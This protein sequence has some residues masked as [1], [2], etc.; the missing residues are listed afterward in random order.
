MPD[1]EITGVDEAQ[2]A[3]EQEEQPQVE[4]TDTEPTTVPVAALED[5][6]RKRQQAEQ[7]AYQYQQALIQQQATRNA[8]APEQPPQDILREIGISPDDIYTQEGVQRFASGIDGLVNKRV[9]EA[10]AQIKREMQQQTFSQ[11]YTDYAELVGTQGPLGFQPAPALQRAMKENP[12]LQTELQS[13]QDPTAAQRLAYSYA[14]MAKRIMDLEAQ[15]PQQD[16]KTTVQAR[17]APMSP[18]AVGA[19]GAFTMA[20]TVGQ[21]SDEEFDRMD[22]EAAGS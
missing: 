7:A 1:E 9:Q 17:T 16:I 3:A 12:N 11:Q 13:V 18:A 15:N 6:R 2:A 14:K 20:Q 8:V 22:R 5:E 19:G 4:A 21:M 10:T